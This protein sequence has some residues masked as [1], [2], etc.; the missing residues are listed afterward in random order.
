VALALG[1]ACDPLGGGRERDAVAGQAGADRDRDRQVR[2][3]GAG[4]A[5]QDDVLAGVQEVELPEVLDDL[6]G[7]PSAGR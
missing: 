4:R 6:A 1:Q 3:A 7:G 5:E 2:L